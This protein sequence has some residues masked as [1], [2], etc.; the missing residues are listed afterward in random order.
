MG[1]NISP[2]SHTNRYK[3]TE[4]FTI[5]LMYKRLKDEKIGMRERA[6]SVAY[7]ITHF[8]FFQ[9]S[10]YRRIRSGTCCVFI[11]SSLHHTCVLVAPES[12]LVYSPTVCSGRY[13]YSTLCFPFPLFQ[14]LQ[15]SHVHL[16]S[17]NVCLQA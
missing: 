8:F 15:C 6:S 2:P 17:F 16:L 10:L 7:S 11:Q 14:E 4:L 9:I 3:H 12:V 13:N 5:M 1:E